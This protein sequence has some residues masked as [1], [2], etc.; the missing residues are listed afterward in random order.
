MNTFKENTQ[1][2]TKKIIFRIFRKKT[3]NKKIVS[4]FFQKVKEV[5]PPV[6]NQIS[7]K[8]NDNIISEVNNFVQKEEVNV[9]QDAAKDRME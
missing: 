6:E 2:K 4:K 8:E 9:P 7:D 1:I 5:V 3:Y